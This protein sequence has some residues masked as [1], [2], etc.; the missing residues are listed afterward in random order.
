LLYDLKLFISRVNRDATVKG[1]NHGR[2][3]ERDQSLRF[4]NAVARTYGDIISR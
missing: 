3:I 4:F 2:P 1:I